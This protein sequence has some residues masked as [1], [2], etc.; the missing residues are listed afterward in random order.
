MVG[1]S[2]TTMSMILFSWQTWDGSEEKWSDIL[3]V[4]SAQRNSES[5]IKNLLYGWSKKSCKNEGSN[6]LIYN[7]Y[8]SHVASLITYCMLLLLD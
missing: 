8:E 6:T 5:D 3:A 2:F 7:Q 4:F 1:R